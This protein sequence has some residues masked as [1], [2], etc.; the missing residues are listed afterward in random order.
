VDWF[1]HRR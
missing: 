1:N